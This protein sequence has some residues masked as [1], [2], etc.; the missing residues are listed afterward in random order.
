MLCQWSKLVISVFIALSTW[1][2]TSVLKMFPDYFWTWVLT[3]F[4]TVCIHI[5]IYMNHAE[6]RNNLLHTCSL[7]NSEQLK[8]SAPTLWFSLICN[9][10]KNESRIAIDEKGKKLTLWKTRQ[11]SGTGGWSQA[12]TLALWINYRWAQA[13]EIHSCKPSIC[14][15][16][17]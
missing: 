16:F 9:A 2:T 14:F 3:C 6:F 8:L 10:S 15:F 4:P 12:V 13:V 11:D 17:F 1:A 7:W 5:R